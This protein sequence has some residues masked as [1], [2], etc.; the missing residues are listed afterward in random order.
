MLPRDR[1]RQGEG[2]PGGEH[3]QSHRFE[4]RPAEFLSFKVPETQMNFCPV[5]AGY[6]SDI[7]QDWRQRQRLSGVEFGQEL[8]HALLHPRRRQSTVYLMEAL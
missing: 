1:V 3:C 6:L 2:C 5:S 4:I 7:Q 8:L